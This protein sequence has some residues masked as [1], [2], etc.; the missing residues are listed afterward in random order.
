MARYRH[1]PVPESIG[2]DVPTPDGTAEII[3][4][5]GGKPKKVS[6]ADVLALAAAP[7]AADVTVST[8]TTA[9]STEISG[10][11]QEVLEAIADLADPA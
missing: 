4:Y 5:V 8:F 3:V 11:L 10:T 2:D 9:G 7:S 1:M 6:L